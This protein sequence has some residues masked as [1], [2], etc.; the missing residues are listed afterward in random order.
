MDWRFLGSLSDARKSGCSGVYLIVHQGV[1]DR[2]VYVGVSNN[3][4]RRMSEHYYNYLK[5]YRTIY[6][7]GRD[8]DVYKYMSAY[9]IYNHTKYY[10]E[11][12]NQGKIWASTTLNFG[13]PKNLLS[14][15]QEFDS[16]WESILLDKYLP[17]LVVWAL[18][19]ANYSYEK[20]TV[21]ESV[22]QTK[23]IT[24]F[25]LRGFFNLKQLSILGK[26]E[27]PQLIKIPQRI[28][29]PNL[30]PASQIVFNNLH[31]S[32]G[33]KRANRI[34]STQLNKEI[35]QR[36]KKKKDWLALR[37][38]KMSQYK[39]YGKPWTYE[40]LEKL[41][42]MLVD[43]NMKPS[44][45]VTYLERSSWSIHKRIN[46]NDKLSMNKWRESLKWL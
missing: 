12:A 4:G 23:L 45:M 27:H 1:F 24:S 13:N 44:E 38:K 26:I 29:S 10:K 19:F 31:A 30:D 8:D 11:L 9:K 32:G 17:Q 40:D 35:K 42:V 25:D 39:N 20:A 36:E 33:L 16:Q 2:V 7:A 14:K 43:F 34:F 28:D 46:D 37:Q 3:V 15:N 41:R 22:I 6:N 5:G 18:P 21:I